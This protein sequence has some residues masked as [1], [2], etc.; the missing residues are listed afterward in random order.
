M[1]SKLFIA[2]AIL[3]SAI[4]VSSCGKLPQ[5]K[6]DAAQAAL[7]SA[8]TVQA[9]L[10]VPQE[11]T[12]AQDSMNVVLASIEEKKSKLFKKFDDET[13]KLDAIVVMANTA[14]TNA[15]TRKAEVIAEVQT[16]ITDIKTL[17]SENL[18]LI[19]KAPKGKEGAAALEAMKADIAAIETAVA[20]AEALF[21]NADYLTALDKTK[22]A[23]EKAVAINTELKEVI[24]KVSSYRK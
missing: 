12:A 18:E 22:A 15:Q 21:A 9:D 24:A 8:K 14:V 3:G 7:D 17:V 19:K 10:Y 23:K 6:I 2:I 20:E 5:E 1:K 16:N 4:V 13:A 11:Y